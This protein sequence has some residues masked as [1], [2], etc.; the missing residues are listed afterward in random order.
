MG[1]EENKEVVRQ[2]LAGGALMEKMHDDAVWNIP[3]TTRFSST[4]KGKQDITDRLIGPLVAELESM[5]SV[6]L[7]NIV[8]EGDYVVVQS[9]ASG[10][11]TKTGNPYN[12]NYCFVFRLEDGKIK[13]VTEYCDTELITA[14]FGK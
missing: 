10:R 4:F 6:S 3:G 5:G 9:T 12:N 1:I 8:A 7:D 13:E 2:A 11:Q 14:A